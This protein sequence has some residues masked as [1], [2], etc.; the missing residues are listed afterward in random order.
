[1]L[2][3][4]G[5]PDSLDAVGPFMCNLM[6][7]EPSDALVQRVCTRY[8]AIGGKSPLGEIAA[9]MAQMLQQSLKDLGHDVP[10]A[11]GMRYW[12]PFIG[13]AFEHL[14]SLGCDRIVTVSLSP[15]ESKVAHGAYRE[16]LAQAS[17]AAGGVEV[18]EAPLLSELEDYVEFFAM[19]AASALDDVQPD[20][21]AIIAFTA[22]SL[23]ESDLVDNDPYVA[24]LRRVATAIAERMGMEPGGSGAGTMLG[25]L[26][27]FG[28]MLPPRTWFL[29]Y[30]SQGQRP[31]AWLGP[32]VDDLID[33]AAATTDYTSVVAVP[34][35][36]ATDHMET[37]Y[38][39]DIMAADRALQADVGFVRAAVPND[40]ER[41]IRAVAES[42]SNLI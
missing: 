26:D 16:A 1:M 17:D 5:G 14:M 3:G 12:N 21:G 41:L 23:P 8:L 35:G 42:V 30:Q 7:E 13:E 9:D 29:V 18:V 31:G 2:V 15:F 33:A 37:L 39:L 32:S 25:G 19:A 34:I 4:F 24:G 22:H 6:G 36:F 28:S 11:V 38:D 10:V 20:T 40:N 27:A